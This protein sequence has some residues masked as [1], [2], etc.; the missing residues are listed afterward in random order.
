MS[1]LTLSALG[2][3]VDDAIGAQAVGPDMTR[4]TVVCV[5]L[6]VCVLLLA[7]GFKRFIGTS[8]RKRAS[9]RSMQVLDVLPLGGKQKLVV[10]RCYDRNFLLGVGDKELRSIAE[11]DA[12]DED[13]APEPDAVPVDAELAELVQTPFRTRL[14]EA[15]RSEP[16]APKRET[17]S[18][19]KPGAVGATK[20]WNGGDGILG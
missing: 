6:L 10:V 12:Q 7:W 4:Y 17:E 19:V 15:I 20:P 13:E 11:L 3:L 5:G 14:A 8:L 1:I 16:R 2:L 9:K 18:A